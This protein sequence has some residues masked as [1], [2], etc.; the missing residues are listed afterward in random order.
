MMLIVIGFVVLLFLGIPIAYVL[1]I[2]TL[3]Y[4][5][6]IENLALLASAPQRMVSGV[7]NYGLLAIPLFVLV[8]EIMNQGGITTRLVEFAKVL[9]GHLR[10]GLAY[11]NIVANMFLAAIM[12]SAN[13]QTAMMSKVMVPAMEKEGYKREFSTALTVSSALI[14][15]IIP[16]SMVFIIYAVTAEVSIGKMFMGGIIPGI[17]LGLGFILL[18]YFISLK[19]NFPKTERASINRIVRSFVSVLPALSIPLIIIIGIMSGVFT[20][21]ESAAVATFVAL[22]LGKYFY[23]ELKFRDLPTIFINTAVNSSVVTFIIAMATIFGWVL[24][25]ERIPQLVAQSLINFSDSPI[26]FLLLC[27]LLFLFIGMFIEGIAAIIILVPVLLP[28]AVSFGIDPVQF[29]IILCINLTIGLITPPVGTAMFIASSITKVKMETLSRALVPFLVVAIIVLA[30]VTYVPKLT[31][32]IPD[33][34]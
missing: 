7:S 2:T 13:A 22:V 8:G 5:L 18:V 16:P 12:G 24:T 9:L 32:W 20:A 23:K 15:P 10:G 28:V 3:L 31:L 21:T 19:A 6:S 1:G 17:I 4:I 14:G 30:L 27:N 33:L 25:F 29:G 26:V 34:V 11:V